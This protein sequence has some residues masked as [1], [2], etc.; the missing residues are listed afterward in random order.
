[1]KNL[2]TGLI[3]VIMLSFIAC[4]GGKRSGDPKIL[5]F[6]KTA[7]FYHQSIP[8]G[9][10]AIQKLGVENGFAVDTTTNAAL[11]TF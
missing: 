3:A 11:F 1:M 5:V 2:F 9:I 6:S 4:S 8:D 10:A 7:G